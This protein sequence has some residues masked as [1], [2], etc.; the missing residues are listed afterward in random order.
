MHIGQK[1]GIDPDHVEA[2]VAKVIEQAND[3]QDG[4]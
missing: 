1:L 4:S 3:S 2:V